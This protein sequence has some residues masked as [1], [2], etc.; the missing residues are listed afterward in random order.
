MSSTV[1]T[2][3]EDFKQL[4]SRPEKINLAVLLLHDVTGLKK[5]DIRLMLEYG[6]RLDDIYSQDQDF[7]VN[8]KPKAKI[9][10]NAKAK[11]G[12]RK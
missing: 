7:S 8:K 5:K 9:R 3:S 10:T 11:N 4:C 12:K 6:P 2:I 1:E